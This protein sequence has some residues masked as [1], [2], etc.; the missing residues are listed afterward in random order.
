MWDGGWHM[1][2]MWLFGPMGLLVLLAVVWAITQSNQ[3]PW[4]GSERAAPETPEQ[5]LKRRYASGEIDED[6][7]QTKLADL[8]R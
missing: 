3:R 2:W 4:T 6:E 5:I 7:F 1:M 8:R